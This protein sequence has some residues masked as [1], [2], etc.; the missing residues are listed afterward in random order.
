MS[1]RFRGGERLQRGRGIGGLLRL[2]K[3]LFKPILKSAKAAI[4]SNA[5]KA[6]GKAVTNQLVESGA[7]IAT[8]ALMGNDVNESV[9]RELQ[10]T[11]QK[12][13]AG[14]Q[15][16]KRKIQQKRTREEP[17]KKK[18]VEKSKFYRILENYY[19]ESDSD[20]V[21][22]SMQRELQNAGQNVAVGIQI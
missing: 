8:D 19:C 16:L 20:D 3:G 5:A 13:V 4:T 10:N 17:K 2:A 9:Y 7:N 1:L 15:N 14:V 12:A 11:K 21:N 6:I 18:A 22:E